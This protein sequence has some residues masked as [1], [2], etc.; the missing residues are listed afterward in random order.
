MMLT[1]RS[2]S[3]T[4]LKLITSHQLAASTR[5][6]LLLDTS[7]MEHGVI[8][9]RKKR[10]RKNILMK[11]SWRMMFDLLIAFQAHQLELRLLMLLTLASSRE[12]NLKGLG[13]AVSVV[14]WTQFYL[15]EFDKRC[16]DVVIGQGSW[17]AS[18]FR[19]KLEEELY[20]I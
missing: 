20:M 15:L 9:R 3:G 11:R 2:T 10:K 14:T 19:E 17:D 8:W 18:E 5:I 13:F 6:V 1:A 7:V 16:E 12:R 4:A